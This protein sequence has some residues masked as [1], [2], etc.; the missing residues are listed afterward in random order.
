MNERILLSL[1]MIVKDEAENLGKCLSSVQ[2][3]ADQIVVVDTG[4]RDNS[5]NIAE[6]YG[7]EVYSYPWENDFS[8]ARNFALSKCSGNFILY[9]DADEALSSKSQ[10]NLRDILK[11]NPDKGLKCLIKNISSNSLAETYGTYCRVFPA[12]KNIQFEG[13]VHE[14]IENSL[15]RNNIEIIDSDIEILHYGYCASPE[16]ILSKAGRNLELLLEEFRVSPS[17]YTAYQLGLTYSILGNNNK[18]KEFFTLA[19][20]EESLPNDYKYFCYE[21]LT[22]YHLQKRNN[23]DAKAFLDKMI[24]TDDKRAS[25][26]L[27]AS[28]IYFSENNF[29]RALMFAVSSYELNIAAKNEKRGLVGVI[30]PDEEIVLNGLHIAINSNSQKYFS[31]FLNLYDNLGFSTFTDI[32]RKLHFQERLTGEDIAQLINSADEYK[33]NIILLLLKNYH[34]QE[35]TLS[36]MEFLAQ[37]FE[38]NSFF[39]TNYSELLFQNG[40]KTEAI[41]LLETKFTQFENNPAPAFYLISYYIDQSE[42]NKLDTPLQFL[43]T[44]FPGDRNVLDGLQQINQKIRIILN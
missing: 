27:L 6:E 17:P 4:S 15:I 10:A 11:N 30:L 9:L 29:E 28:K 43:E 37:R 23:T 3:V 33:I 5:Q 14:Q 21:F 16:I 42:F 18:A 44:H 26:H 12:G 32:F 22:N 13:R 25:A 40:K 41:E 24:E 19:V 38:D 20:D 7:A 1:L 36:A 35:I 34:Y 2:N 8:A 31:H 39:V